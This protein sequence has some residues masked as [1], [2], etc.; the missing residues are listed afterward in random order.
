MGT[1]RSIEERLQAIEDELAAQRPLLDQCVGYIQK[2]ALAMAALH[3]V[4]EAGERIAVAQDE[5]EPAVNHE[6]PTQS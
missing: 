5:R 6:G 3:R 1:E 2:T 4:I